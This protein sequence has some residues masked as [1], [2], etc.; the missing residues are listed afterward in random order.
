MMAIRFE[1]TRLMLVAALA[2]AGCGLYVD[3]NGERATETRPLQG[4]T[5]VSADGPL[6]V[7]IQRGD[8]FDVQVSIDSNVLRDLRTD[9]IDGGATLSIDLDGR[10]WDILPGPHVI[11]TMPALRRAVLNGS[12]SVS[13]TGFQ[14]DD[15]VALELDGSGVLTYGGDVPSAQVRSWGSGDVR[16]HGSAGSLDARLD[17]SGAVDARDFPTATADLSL[18]GSGDLAANVTGSARVTLSGS[19]NVDLYGGAVVAGASISG[20]GSFTQH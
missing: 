17:G 15:A 13:A 14:Q 6:D 18:S 4:F 3:G 9:L 8:S 16:L 2:A 10:F 12:G 19:G 11:V 7:Q 20:S 5:A 1:T